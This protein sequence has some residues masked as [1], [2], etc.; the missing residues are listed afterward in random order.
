[1]VASRYQA[2]ARAWRKRGGNVR[3]IQIDYDCPTSRLSGYSRWL[4][5]LKKTLRGEPEISVTGLGDWLVSAE[6]GD[7]EALFHQTEYVAF[8]MYHG[9]RQLDPVAPFTTALV[10]ATAPFKL[11]LLKD[12][13][14]NPAFSD[15]RNAPGYTGDIQYILPE[16][17]K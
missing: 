14:N 15:V 9:R 12:Q 7:L 8:M 16:A 1:M 3:G 13:R 6:P 2:H 4:E 5:R 10:R 17:R 11:G